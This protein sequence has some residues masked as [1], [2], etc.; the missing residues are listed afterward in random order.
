MGGLRLPD[1]AP[2]RDPRDA[3]KYAKRDPFPFDDP[4]IDEQRDRITTSYSSKRLSCRLAAFVLRHLAAR[5]GGQQHD[6]NRSTARVLRHGRATADRPT[7][8]GALRQR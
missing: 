5:R 7:A 6:L 1:G 2:P 8:R 4:W 3:W